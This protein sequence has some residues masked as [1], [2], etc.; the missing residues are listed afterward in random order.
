MKSTLMF[1]LA[2]AVVLV[3]QNVLAEEIVE[4]YDEMT[5]VLG[6]GTSPTPV[7]PDPEPGTTVWN[8]GSDATAFVQDGVLYVRGSGTVTNAPW[9]SAAGTVQKVKIAEDVTSIPSGALDG[10]TGL[11]HVNGMA[12]SVFNN[13]SA[14]A[15]KGG[16][17]TAIAIDPSSQT[18]TVTFRVKSAATADAP[19]ADWTPVEATGTAADPSDATAIHVPISASS[20]AGFFKVL[21]D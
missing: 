9:A 8:V 18:G 14:A 21:A 13:V 19:E 11:T 5:F 4:S 3:A 12:L 17:F 15:V 16:G 7:D 2:A 6:T 20:P 1:A 10:M